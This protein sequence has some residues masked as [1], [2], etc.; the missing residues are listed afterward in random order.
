[1]SRF[2]AGM[3]RDA[4]VCYLMPCISPRLRTC[5]GIGSRN[6]PKFD[7]LQASNHEGLS[8]S[9]TF[10]PRDLCEDSRN[11][12]SQLGLP[13]GQYLR[14]P[15]RAHPARLRRSYAPCITS[16]SIRLGRLSDA[17]VRHHKKLCLP[18]SVLVAHFA[19]GASI[20]SQ[21]VRQR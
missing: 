2:I 13:P 14:R 6:G 7:G 20:F 21:S 8:T 10:R 11:P 3:R 5:R 12:E 17:I 19:R 1:M 4:R 18:V 16:T 9:T 15:R